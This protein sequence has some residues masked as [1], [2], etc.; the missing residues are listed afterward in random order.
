[1]YFL[2]FLFFVVIL[3][4]LQ[5]EH[6]IE[7]I[8]ETDPLIDYLK[9]ILKDVHPIIQTIPI[10]KSKKSYT[11]NKKKIYLCITDSNGEYYSL[12]MIVY[13]LLHEVAHILC[14]SHG[15]TDEFYTIFNELIKK[16]EELG[17]YNKNVKYIDNYR[18]S[19][20]E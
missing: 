16:A 18:G 8:S 10:Y 14:I 11:L 20:N 13:V 9:I 5:K 2:C 1:M 17:V 12:N 19:S 4:F 15:H 6:T 3:I 7:L